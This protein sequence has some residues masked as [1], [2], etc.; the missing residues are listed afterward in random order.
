MF[1]V[2]NRFRPGPNVFWTELRPGSDLKHR[3]RS[4]NICILGTNLSPSLS[5]I[6][7]RSDALPCMRINKAQLLTDIV[8]SYHQRNTPK[9]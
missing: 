7:S 1:K 3:S 5:P 8:V 6:R 4:T 9:K 2:Q